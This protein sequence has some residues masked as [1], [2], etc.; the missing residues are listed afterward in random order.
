MDPHDTERLV[1]AVDYD[2]EAADQALLEKKGVDLEAF[3][4]RQVL[5]DYRPPEASV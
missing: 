3:L 2:A 5:Y 4:P 1:L